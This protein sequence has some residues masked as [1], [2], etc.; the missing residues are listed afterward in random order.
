ML[1]SCEQ[2]SVVFTRSA[3]SNEFNDSTVNAFTGK[4]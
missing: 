4:T 2:D 3:M 1:A